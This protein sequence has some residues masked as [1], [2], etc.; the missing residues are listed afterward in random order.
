MTIEGQKTAGHPLPLVS[1]EQVTT[2]HHLTS[3]SMEH[4]LK[5][6][7]RNDNAH[8]SCSISV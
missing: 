3:S 1:Q 6:T 2:A 7:A 4:I 8:H 5:I